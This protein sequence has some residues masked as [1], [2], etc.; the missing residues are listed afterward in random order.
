[1]ILICDDFLYDGKSLKAQNYLTVD[2]EN[3]DSLPSY[4]TREMDTSTMNQYRSETNGFGIRYS[5]TLVLDIHVCKDFCKYD[6]Q[7]EQAFTRE[8]YD[9]LVSWLTSP[10]KNQWMDVTMETGVVQKVKGYFSSVEPYSVDGTCYGAVCTFTCNSPFSYTE[11]TF[12]TTV[13]DVTNFI[14]SNNGSDYYDYVYPTITL[15]PAS[16]GDMY[17]HNLSDSEILEN[18]SLGTGGSDYIAS[19]QEKVNTYAMTHG[20]TVQYVIDDDTK[21]LKLIC[22][23]SGFLFYMT[24]SYGIRKKYGAYFQDDGQYWIFRNGFFYCTLSQ[25]LD[26]TMDCKNLGFY[27]VLN[28][29]VLFT[30]LDIQDEDEIYWPRLVHG[31]NTFR[32]SG[33]LDITVSFMEPRKGMLI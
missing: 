12:S 20:L 10:Q 9:S 21:D 14:I 25:A 33:S 19:L 22:N 15:E 28:R 13:S 30:E 27:D 7:S 3:D 5:E 29:P 17:I 23:E 6:L 8:E 32:V 11:K 18:G 24:D 2:F 26:L 4:I 1:M 16:N 31:N